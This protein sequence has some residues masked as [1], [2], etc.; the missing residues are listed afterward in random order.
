MKKEFL[1]RLKAKTPKFFKKL[2]LIALTL[3]GSAVAM[4]TINKAMEL[5]IP[6]L[7]I[8]ICEKA[9]FICAGIAGTAT[10]TKI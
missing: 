3:G 2:R 5:G 9:A 6:D 7:W 1:E 4:L 10:L 8:T